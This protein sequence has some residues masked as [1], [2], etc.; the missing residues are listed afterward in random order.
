M[1]TQY[2]E[3]ELS[4]LSDEEREALADADMS[5][6]ALDKI[7]GDEDEDEDED[8]EENEDAAIAAKPEEEPSAAVEEEPA[9]EKPEPEVF[10]TQYRVDP[11]DGFD[12]KIA[13]LS[14]QKADLR[15]ALNEGDLTLDDY[16]AQK[17]A[18]I[19][20]ERELREQKL[21]ADIAEDQNKQTAIARWEWEQE[22][23]FSEKSNEIYKDDLV[24]AAFDKA[25]RSLG[26][27]EA[28]ANR[29]GAW[30]LQEADKQVRA[31][32]NMNAE[33]VKDPKEPKKNRQPDLSIVPKTLSGVPGADIPDTG[34]VDEFA[35]L[36]RLSGLDL[37]KAVAKLSPAEQERYLAA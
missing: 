25:V 21:K 5:T 35:H 37:E 33:P 1:G 27:D 10:T 15:K 22:R 28:N 29:P 17:D 14:T 20:Q 13:A 24:M 23:F 30:F 8:K 32:F 4:M 18:I 19:E 16:E 9:A 2:T 31:R 26:K 7:I 11:V 34:A 3:E 6:E 12:E 36:D